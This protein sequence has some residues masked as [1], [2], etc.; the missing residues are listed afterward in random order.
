ML[1]QLSYDCAPLKFSD[2]RP[3]YAT[4]QCTVSIVNEAVRD[5]MSREIYLKRKSQVSKSGGYSENATEDEEDLLDLEPLEPGC[6]TSK[7]L[8]FCLTGF[9]IFMYA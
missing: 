8:M 6:K 4:F 2:H 3:V 9:L 7:L 5:E 1:R